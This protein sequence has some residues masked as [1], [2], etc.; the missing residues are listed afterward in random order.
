MVVK[1]IHDRLK[2][3]LNELT[4]FKQI[5][6]MICS[7]FIRDLIK[8]GSYTISHQLDCYIGT[9]YDDINMACYKLYIKK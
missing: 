2:K 6:V 3:Y 7:I 8:N 4:S 9:L 1:W 5:S